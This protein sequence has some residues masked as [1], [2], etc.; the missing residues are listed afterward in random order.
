MCTAIFVDVGD[1]YLGRNLDYEKT[2]GEKVV[3]TPRN[4]KF[5]FRNGVMQGHHYAFIGTAL[6]Y[7]DYPLYFEAVNEAGLSVAALR[8]SGNAFYNPIDKERDN[9]ASFELIPWLLCRCKDVSKA[10]ELV[11]NINITNEAFSGSMPPSPLHWLISDKERSVVLEQTKKGLFLYENPVGVLSNNPT[12]DIQLFNLNNFMSLSNLEPINKFSDKIEL[13]PY[14][15]GMGAMGLPGDLSSMSR[16]VRA[17]F[18]KSKSV[19]RGEEEDV[20]NRLFHILYSVYQIE[21]CVKVEEDFEKTNYSACFNLKKCIYYYTTYENT[22]IRKIELF[23][24][25]LEEDTLKIYDLYEK[26]NIVSRN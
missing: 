21:G 4:Y 13:N 1:S 5:T 11:K 18:I 16:F 17:S 19:F 9:V 10:E 7:M 3:I 25:N 14:S 6:P 12:F 24:E 15:R 22:N 23:K 20:V 2:F 26:Q 8:F